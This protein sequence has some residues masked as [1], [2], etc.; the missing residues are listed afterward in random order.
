MIPLPL[1]GNVNQSQMNPHQGGHTSGRFSTEMEPSYN[2][3]NLPPTWG[4]MEVGQAHWDVLLSQGRGFP[5][6]NYFNVDVNRG[7]LEI[8]KGHN[9]LAVPVNE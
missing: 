1:T 9:A 7:D 2:L 5:V 3:L 6:N 4:E 8:D